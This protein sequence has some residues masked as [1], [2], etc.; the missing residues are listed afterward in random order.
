[1]SVM[2]NKWI[3]ERFELPAADLPDLNPGI[4]DP[5][6]AAAYV[7]GQW[8][9]GD[10]PISNVLHLVEAH[11]VRVYA[12]AYEC[13]E[14][15][16]FS[17]WR[18]DTPFVCLG[19]HK[20]AERAVFDLAHE[21][22]H[23]ILHRDQSAPRGRIEELQAD[24]FAANFL[25]PKADVAAAAPPFPTFDDLVKAKRRWSVSAA[26]LNYR[27]HQ[28]GFISD[29]HYRALCIEI[30]QLGRDKE[31]NPI[32]RELSQILAKVLSALRTEGITRADIAADLCLF[33]PDLDSLLAGLTI[34]MID[35]GGEP[36]GN[37]EGRPRLSV[38]GTQS[39]ARCGNE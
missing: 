5:E 14:I 15:D 12:L 1:M 23:L 3:E 20:T 13:R 32:P 33:Q 17:F 38:V 10:A 28:L 4:I 24:L 11:G 34:S 21:L 37:D 25:M 30:S 36:L 19:T 8:H 29:W 18:D 9:L 31:F 22:A 27:L 7:R 16:A 39:I 26:A 35:G 2:L 6:G